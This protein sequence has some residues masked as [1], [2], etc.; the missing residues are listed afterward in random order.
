MKCSTRVIET[1]GWVIC[2]ALCALGA[3]HALPGPAPM[4][5]AGPVRPA[6]QDQ[7]KDL[8]DSVSRLQGALCTRQKRG[9]DL[10]CTYGDF[11]IATYPAGCGAHGFYGMVY[12][13]DSQT[14]VVQD[15]FPNGRVVAKLH[16]EQLVCTTAEAR[17][18]GHNDVVW[19]YLKAIPRDSVKACNGKVACGPGNL[20]VDWTT[21]VQ[22]APCHRSADGSYTGTCATGW[23]KAENFSEFS[24]GL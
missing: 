15:G 16:D 5:A 8:P 20:P 2:A 6:A 3:A 19:Y 23:V 14:I 21:P 4:G 9:W 13:T 24:N 10:Q 18:S 17:I 7:V 22:G 11:E 12:A 1:I